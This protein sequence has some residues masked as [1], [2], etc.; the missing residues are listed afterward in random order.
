MAPGRHSSPRRAHSSSEQ[1]SRRR[2]RW[3]SQRHCLQKVS[4]HGTTPGT[5]DGGRTQQGSLGTAA[6][7]AAAPP[8]PAQGRDAL[9]SSVK[10]IHGGVTTLSCR[11][12][13][14]ATLLERGR[15]GKERG[16]SGHTSAAAAKR[17]VPTPLTSPTPAQRSRTSSRLTPRS[18]RALG[19]TRQA[20]RC[21]CEQAERSPR[22]P[23]CCR[24]T[25]TT[26][27][28]EKTHNQ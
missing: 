28:M 8:W 10:S 27:V 9:C 17:P 15:T 6:D 7:G 22:P 25:R 20:S 16:R 24:D 23:Q 3:H 12:C 14:P 2:G 26:V 21:G 18:S 11:T 4:L 1:L 19:R 5:H 13:V